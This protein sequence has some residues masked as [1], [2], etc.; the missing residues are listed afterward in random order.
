MDP[1]EKCITRP[2]TP[3][4]PTEWAMLIESKLVII[5][6]NSMVSGQQVCHVQHVLSPNNICTQL[7]YTFYLNVFRNK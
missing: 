1:L 7:R 2:E 6:K 4:S 5:Y 3:Y